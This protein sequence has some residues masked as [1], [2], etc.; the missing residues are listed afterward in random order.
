[1]ENNN[2]NSVKSILK[3]F[4]IIETL[5]EA[6]PLSISELS[7]ALQMDKGTVHRLI[8]TVRQAGYVIQ[9]PE[10]KKYANSIKLFE[11]GQKVVTRTGLYDLARPHIEALAQ[12][13]GESINLGIVKDNE[14]IYID[15]KEGMS[16]IKVGIKIGTSIPMYCTGM[17]KAVLAFM[18]PSIRDEIISRIQYVRYSVNTPMDQKKVEQELEDSRQKGYSMDNEEYVN[19]LISFGAPIFGYKGEPVAAISISFPKSRFTEEYAREFPEMVK[20]A[21]ADISRQMGYIA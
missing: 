16:T 3:A 5:N 1:M 9:N 8:N 2:G 13:T 6:G 18:R 17:G 7:Q 19:D 4:A 20:K 10:T 21:A 15:K 14:I 11:I 12:A